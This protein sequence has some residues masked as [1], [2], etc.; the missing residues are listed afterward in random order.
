MVAVQTPGS[1]SMSMIAREYAESQPP[2]SGGRGIE[3]RLYA[4]NTSAFAIGLLIGP[5]WAAL[6]GTNLGWLWLCVSF[7]GLSAA[8]GLFVVWAYSGSL[9]LS[10]RND[11]QDC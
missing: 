7:S 9:H 1:V 11:I 4:L 8:A 6:F 3:G 5:L 2:S 10:E